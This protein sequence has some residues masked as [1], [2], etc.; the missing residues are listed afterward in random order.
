VVFATESSTA[1]QATSSCHTRNE[2]A[3]SPRTGTDIHPVPVTLPKRDP[4]TIS[5]GPAYDALIAFTAAQH[6]ATLLSLDQRAAATHETVGAQV[7]QLL[8]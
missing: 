7:E 2:N 3:P 8:G 6:N 1:N 4:S 5:G